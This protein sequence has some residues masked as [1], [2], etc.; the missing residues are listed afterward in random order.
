MVDK[1]LRLLKRIEELRHVLGIEDAQRLIEQQREGAKKKK[2]GYFE[3]LNSIK[4]VA[5]NFGYH[6][7]QKDYSTSYRLQKCSDL[8]ELLVNRIAGRQY[9]FQENLIF[10]RELDAIL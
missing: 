1:A 2:L 10:K 5:D 3:S 6:L 9:S 8:F 7:E 4:Y